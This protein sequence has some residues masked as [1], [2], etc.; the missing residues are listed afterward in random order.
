MCFHLL[1]FSSCSYYQGEGK[2]AHR[3]EGWGGGQTC[4]VSASRSTASAPVLVLCL[5][6]DTLHFAFSAPLHAHQLGSCASSPSLL[7]LSRG[8]CGARPSQGGAGC[9]KILQHKQVIPSR[10]VGGFLGNW[11]RNF[12]SLKDRFKKNSSSSNFCYFSAAKRVFYTQF[13]EEPQ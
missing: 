11:K 10:M 12:P 8:L 2:E 6:F 5:A 4:E 9:Q 7:L 1:P 13:S 3:R